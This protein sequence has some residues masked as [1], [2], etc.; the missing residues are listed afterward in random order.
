[1]ASSS[2]MNRL[3]GRTLS[4]WSHTA[5]SIGVIF[6]T[7]FGERVM[8]R[9]FGSAIPRLLGE[10]MVTPTFLK[11]FQAIAIALLQEP[12]VLL[13][14]VTPL[15][16]DRSGAAGFEIEVEYRPRGHLGDF[17]VEGETKLNVVRSGSI[18]VTQD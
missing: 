13:K 8:R 1:M 12:R 3:T 2:G 9:D 17:T 18:F 16:V 4:D 14:K 5:Q 6:T 15:S 11:W 10:N 7:N